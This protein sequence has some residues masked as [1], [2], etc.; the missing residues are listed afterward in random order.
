M[1]MIEYSV[2]FEAGRQSA[3]DDLNPYHRFTRAAQGWNAGAHYAEAGRQE[4]AA[5]RRRVRIEANARRLYDALDGL[6]EDLSE[7][8]EFYCVRD[9]KELLDEIDKED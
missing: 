1:T 4:L 5:E 6:V 2:G 8:A 3:K 7:V 9:A